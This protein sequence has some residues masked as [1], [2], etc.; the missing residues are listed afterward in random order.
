[1]ELSLGEGKKQH[2]EGKREEKKSNLT[3]DMPLS[4]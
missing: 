4:I 2:R 3:E 1:M